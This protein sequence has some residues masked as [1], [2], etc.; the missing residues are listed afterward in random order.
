MKWRQIADELRADISEGRLKPGDQL[1]GQF[2]LMDKHK[3]SMATVVRALD[4]LRLAGLVQT[5]PGRGTFVLEQKPSAEYVELSGQIADLAEQ[6]RQLRET[7]AELKA[8]RQAP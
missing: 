4:D 7:V 5:T 1:P 2:V 8:G 6:V 3:V